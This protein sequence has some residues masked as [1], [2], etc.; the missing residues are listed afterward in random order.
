MNTEATTNGKATID[1]DATMSGE[2]Q[3]LKILSYSNFT[4]TIT[5]LH[6]DC[7]KENVEQERKNFAM[8]HS[9]G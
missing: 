5:V 8:T 2:L 1:E 6:K 7:T 4:F 9:T 3:S